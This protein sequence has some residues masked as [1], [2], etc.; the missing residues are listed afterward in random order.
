MP[1]HVERRGIGAAAERRTERALGPL[2]HVGWTITHD[3]E[4]PGAG[5]IDHL[6]VGLPGV[7]VLD[8]KAW[9]GVVTVDHDGATITPRDDPE[10][11]WLARGQRRVAARTTVRVTRAL[12]A[13]TG[14][15]VPAA[16]SVVV[17]W[18]NFPQRVATSGEVT[19]VAGGHLHDWLLGQRARL[20][21]TQLA[22]V[23]AANTPS[24]FADVPRP[25]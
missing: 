11:A 3:L 19:Y 2:A 23:S 21:R 24:L 22:A 15:T 12:A 13:A 7:F 8:S 25:V 14:M 4:L 20:N 9:S 18:G 10:A 1:V 16:H 5:N 17:V 6:A